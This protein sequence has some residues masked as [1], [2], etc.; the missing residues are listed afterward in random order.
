MEKLFEIATSIKTPLALGGLI[1]VIF[2]FIIKKIINKID[3]PK[4]VQIRADILKKIINFSFMLAI[5]SVILGFF[6][7]VSKYTDF[8]FNINT[9]VKVAPI[10]VT[11][12]EVKPIHITIDI[13]LKTDKALNDFFSDIDDAAAN[14]GV[15]SVASEKGSEKQ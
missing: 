7:Y 15:E 11:P 2:F 10:T 5:F 8:N 14:T 4:S 12:I 3:I 13:N 6:G 9:N 1:A